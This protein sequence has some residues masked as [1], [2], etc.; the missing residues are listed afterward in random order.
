MPLV[1][2]KKS[3]PVTK[4]RSTPQPAK[5]KKSPQSKQKIADKKVSLCN[6]YT[7]TFRIEIA[8]QQT[9]FTASFQRCSPTQ[10]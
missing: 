3:S 8:F 10:E 6:I 5:K 9:C 1:K 4:K 2:K 7:S